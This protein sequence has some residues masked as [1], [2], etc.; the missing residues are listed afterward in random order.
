MVEVEDKSTLTHATFVAN[1]NHVLTCCD[2]D[3]EN[4]KNTKNTLAVQ[5]HTLALQLMERIRRTADLAKLLKGC[6]T[7]YA[8]GATKNRIVRSFKELK[9]IVAA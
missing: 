4:T 5:P 1:Q 8:L 7:D 9:M 6:T 3:S 2:S